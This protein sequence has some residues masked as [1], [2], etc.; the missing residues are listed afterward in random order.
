MRRNF[1]NTRAQV[2]SSTLAEPSAAQDSVEVFYG[3][4]TYFS[5]SA[6]R[7][8]TWTALAIPAGPA[9][10]SIACCD[11]DAVHHPVQDTTFHTVLYTNASQTN[12]VVRIFV[13]R[14]TIA[15]YD[16]TYLIDPGGTAN[17]VLPDYPTSW[18]SATTSST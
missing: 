5:R 6:D 1:R 18:Q 7:G 16:C 2:V 17:N 9:E 10:A 12:G 8:A 4:N 14:S 13:K 11:L 3:G 15:G